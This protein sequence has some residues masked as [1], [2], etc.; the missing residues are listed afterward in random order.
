MPRAR[1][2]TLIPGDGIGPEVTAA[3]VRVIEAAGARIAWDV[4][5]GG[6][7]A[8]ETLGTPIPE[9]LL[10]SIRRNRVALEGC[11]PATWAGPRPR[12]R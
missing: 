12:P 3:A 1:R 6:K 5:E 11:A 8:F 9:P 2:V 10:A 4:H 7:T